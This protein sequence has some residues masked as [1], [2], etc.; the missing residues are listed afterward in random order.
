MGEKHR[1][2]TDKFAVT[3]LP[4]EREILSASAQKYGLT[5]T[6]YIRRLILFGGVTGQP[7]L[8]RDTTKKLTQELSQINTHLQTISYK[9]SNQSIPQD[10]DWSQLKDSYTHLL[11]FIGELAYLKK[12]DRLNWQQQVSTLLQ[13]L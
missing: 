11:G 9:L 5:K 12:E 3:L 2:R 7:L 4:E 10:N 1:I 6:E 8:D 13:K